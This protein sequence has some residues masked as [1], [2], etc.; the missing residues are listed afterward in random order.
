VT[1]EETSAAF[2][3]GVARAGMRVTVLGVRGGVSAL[4]TGVAAS[5][6]RAGVEVRTGWPVES[7]EATNGGV[8]VRGASESAEHEGVVIAVPLAEAARLLPGSPWLATVPTR[9][10]ATLLLALDTPARTGWF[11]LSVPRTEPPGETLAAVCV[12]EEKGTGLVPGGRGAV[13]VIPAPAEAER[14]ARA[15]PGEVLEAAQP[16]LERLL[17][18]VRHRIVEARLVRLPGA[19][20]PAPGHFEALRRGAGPQA[21]A[22][23]ALAG[24][25]LVAPTVEGAVRSG[26]RAAERLT[27]AA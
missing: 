8:L 11:G 18:G 5:L 7:V 24:D 17:P 27:G 10:S 20:I 4:V 22:R 3:H 2:F 15:E 14:W 1:P 16:G 12:Q 9:P 19:F 6:G 23:V 26:L 13:V 25:Y 21:P